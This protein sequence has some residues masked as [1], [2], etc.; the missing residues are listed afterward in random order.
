M[1]NSSHK[2]V[3]EIH[4]LAVATQEATVPFHHVVGLNFR[5]PIF[6]AP[7]SQKAFVG[8][9]SE[10]LREYKIFIIKAGL[11]VRMPSYPRLSSIFD[12]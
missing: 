11:V 2:D 6:C 9:G 5:S 7:L 4:S 3:Y 8:A 12:L 10:K 1:T